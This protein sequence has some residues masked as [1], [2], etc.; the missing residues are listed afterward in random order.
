MVHREL[1]S[2]HFLLAILFCKKNE[3]FNPNH[4][5]TAFIDY[6]T[7]KFILAQSD[8]SLELW[9]TAGEEKFSSTS[10]AYYQGAHFIV[11]LYDVTNPVNL[12]ENTYCS[13]WPND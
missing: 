6:K 3:K 2:H 7:K 1:G 9:D 13:L 12:A 4:D 5:I 8:V 11:L 10:S